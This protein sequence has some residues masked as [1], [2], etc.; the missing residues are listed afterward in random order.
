[1][2]KTITLGP[3]TWSELGFWYQRE[4]ITEGTVRVVDDIICQAVPRTIQFDKPQFDAAFQN[5]VDSEEVW[6]WVPV[7]D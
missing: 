1:M 4:R 6:A 2:K 5:M 7:D 3:Y